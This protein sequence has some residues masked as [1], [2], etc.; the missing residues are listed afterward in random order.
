MTHKV[1]AII[2][3]Y[4]SSLDALRALL[5][6]VL[7]QVQEVMVVDNSDA[8]R[9]QA[10]LDNEALHGLVYHFVGENIGI[11]AA[12]NI[13][14]DHAA[15]VGASHVLLLD[16]DSLPAPDMVCRLLEATDELTHSGVKV[17]AVGPGFR[18]HG[19][20]AP[21]R[22]RQFGVIKSKRVYCH[23]GRPHEYIPADLLISSGSLVSMEAMHAIGY[24]DG[25]LF[26]DLVDTEWI[27]RARAIGYRSFGIC[28]AIMN[29]AL[30]DSVV[31]VWVGQV[32]IVPIHS[33]LRLYYL[34]RNSI[35]VCRRPY[36]PWRWIINHAVYLL[37]RAVFYPCF[38]HPRR[39]YIVM[40]LR[41]LRD[42]MLGKTR[43]YQS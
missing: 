38:V 18:L 1:V 10:W 2:V 14:I 3:T 8:N 41:G 40:I 31:R 11:G 42:G 33:P 39:Q 19:T 30:G 36:I 20:E 6:A 16:D 34:F 29:H 13:G 17:S 15:K 21:P 25:S 9:I 4:N 23:A 43:K 37:L 32:H 22:F 7:P 26:I 12:Q 28:D 5:L 27:L 35:L 24:M